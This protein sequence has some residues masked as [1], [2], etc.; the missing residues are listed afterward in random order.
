MKTLIKS[1]ICA[2]VLSTVLSFNAFADDKDAKKVTGFGTGIFTTKAGKLNVA[3]DKYNKKPTSIVLE[4]P[5][6]GL[7]YKEIVGRH[8]TK[9]RRS[10][11]MSQLPSGEYLLQIASNG[12]KQTKKVQI[13][14]KQP[15]RLI[16]MK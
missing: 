5:N 1:M 10:L 12:E 4:G 3:V 8:Q 14:D 6:G 13:L 11:D 15:E 2:L 9:L 16:S 7:V